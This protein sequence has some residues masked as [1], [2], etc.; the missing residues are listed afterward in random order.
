M[1]QSS[2]NPENLQWQENASA[3]RGEQYGELDPTR[4][5]SPGSVPSPPMYSMPASYP[6]AN[7]YPTYPSSNQYPAYSGMPPGAM[8]PSEQGSGMAI[9]GLVLGIISMIAWLIPLF[10]VP[11]SAVGIVLA[12]LG[13]RSVSRRTMATVGLVLASIAL[14]L[15]L[16]NAALGVYLATQRMHVYGY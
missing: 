8:N 7:Q 11:I 16:C 12:A 1:N 13:R 14:V 6:P 2:D 5:A 3:P 10:G 9:A 4:Q 15:A